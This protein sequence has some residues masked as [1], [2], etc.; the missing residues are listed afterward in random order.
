MIQK[1]LN[2]KWLL[3]AGAINFNAVRKL[4]KPII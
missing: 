4:M 1:T 3:V 2:R